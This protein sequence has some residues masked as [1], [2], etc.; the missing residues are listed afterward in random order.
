[1]RVKPL[2]KEEIK[3]HER[4]NKLMDENLLPSYEGQTKLNEYAF[5][6][7]YSSCPERLEKIT[8]IEREDYGHLIRV[9]TPANR[10]DN[11]PTKH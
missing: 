3:E 4:L 8:D 11:R 5:R 2:T 9:K 1:M 7:E 6:E 10:R